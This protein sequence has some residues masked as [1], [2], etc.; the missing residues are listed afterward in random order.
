MPE[1]VRVL[2]H[3][4]GLHILLEID[5]ERTEQE[6]VEAAE[7]AGVK[8]YP[9]SRN[10]VEPRRDQLPRI[11]VGFGGLKEADI[12]EGIRLLGKAWF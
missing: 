4:A 2:G 6:L 8:V 1:C 10:W 12:G 7:K 5:T 11:I 3:S 9:I